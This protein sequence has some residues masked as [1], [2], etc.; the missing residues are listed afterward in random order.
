MEDEKVIISNLQEQIQLNK[1]VWQKMITF[2]LVLKLENQL[3]N[4]D[5]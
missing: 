2:F 5:F 4:L 1:Q 3:L